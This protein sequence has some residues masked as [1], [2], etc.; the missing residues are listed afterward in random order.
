M[1]GCR[2][3]DFRPLLAVGAAGGRKDVAGTA[4]RLIGFSVLWPFRAV[5]RPSIAE[6]LVFLG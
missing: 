2:V 1:G 3:T 5:L 6:A 4:G